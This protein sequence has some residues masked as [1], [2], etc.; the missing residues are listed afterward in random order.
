[1]TDFRKQITD[2][3]KSL[4]F[5]LVGFT[6]AKLTPK[7]LKA[8]KK[9]LSEGNE[10]EMEYM[11][12]VIPRT[13]LEQ[14]LPGAKSVIVLGMNY[15]YDQK[16]LKKDFGRIARYAFGR[17]YHKIIKKKLK[18]L[19]EFVKSNSGALTKS[20]VDAGPILEKAFAE[21][22]VIGFIGKNGTLI[23]KEFG[24]WV[25]LAEIITTLELIPSQPEHAKN[26]ANNQISQ[27]HSPSA[28]L[29]P[30]TN[31]SCGSCTRCINA[32]PLKAIISPGLIDA[33]RCISYLTIESKKQIPKPLAKIIKSTK[34]LFG[35]DICQEVCPHNIARQ[36]P[37]T[38]KDLKNPKIAGDQL[39]IKKILSIKT[40]KEFLNTFAGSP[41]MRAKTHGLKKIAKIIKGK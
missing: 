6:S 11:K 41:L 25:F 23:T 27:L 19:E 17:D 8:Y 21:Q 16:P 10:G 37:H 1:M 9:W 31:P 2:Y 7:Y 33:R 39:S 15:F 3:A 30:G 14:I 35:C 26:S 34:R 5:D 12:K 29:S 24:S 32:C 18:K 40:D 38:N 13:N 36:K 22:S 4:G 28:K 20:F